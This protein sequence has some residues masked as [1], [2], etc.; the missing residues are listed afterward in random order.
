MQSKKILEPSFLLPL[1]RSPKG[2]T[3]L[4]FLR[5]CHPRLDR[6][7]SSQI[8]LKFLGAFCVYII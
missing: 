8:N 1:L 4:E 3:N 7:I 2:S 5:L 6:G